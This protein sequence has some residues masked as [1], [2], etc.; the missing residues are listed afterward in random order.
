MDCHLSFVVMAVSLYSVENWYVLV[1]L[2]EKRVEREK[3]S[4]SQTLEVKGF[5]IL[6]FFHFSSLS[7]LLSEEV[8]LV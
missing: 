8:F 3:A 7:F 5:G 1:K 4:C 6:I 2:K